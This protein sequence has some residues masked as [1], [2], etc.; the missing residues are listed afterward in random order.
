MTQISLENEKSLILYYLTK[1]SKSIVAKD[2]PWASNNNTVLPKDHKRPSK[3]FQDVSP[4]PPKNDKGIPYWLPIHSTHRKLSA[5][6]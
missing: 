3:D 2:L 4:L 1:P 5:E 6:D